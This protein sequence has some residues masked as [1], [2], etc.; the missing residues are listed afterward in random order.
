MDREP[1]NT[2]L[3]RYDTT[4]APVGVS[5]VSPKCTDTAS[6]TREPAKDLFNVCGYICAIWRH[7]KLFLDFFDKP[8]DVLPGGVR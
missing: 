6:Y 7:V 5:A 4:S 2:A 8:C 1:S 3:Q